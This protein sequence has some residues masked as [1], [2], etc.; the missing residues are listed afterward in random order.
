LLIQYV[1]IA[2]IFKNNLNVFNTTP[3]MTTYRVETF[4]CFVYNLC[5]ITHFN[6][7]INLFLIFDTISVL[8][9]YLRK[10]LS[11]NL[12]FQQATETIDAHVIISSTDLFVEGWNSS[13]KRRRS[14]K[15]TWRKKANKNSLRFSLTN[16][17]GRKAY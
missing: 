14:A 12:F 11:W 5:T 4:V 13:K 17:F 16:L 10:M 15:K 6:V 7:F 8:T 1:V 3:M 2:L 9:H